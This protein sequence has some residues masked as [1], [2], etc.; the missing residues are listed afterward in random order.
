MLSSFQSMHAHNG[1]GSTTIAGRRVYSLRQLLIGL[2]L[3]ALATFR[4][5]R[6]CMT[7][8]ARRDTPGLRRVSLGRRLRGR[9]LR[10]VVLL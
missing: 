5:S 1:I 10:F 7:G 8:C 6:H 2:A 9:R 4:F 3:D